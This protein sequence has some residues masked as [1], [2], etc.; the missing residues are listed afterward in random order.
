MEEDQKFDEK[1]Y[2][3]SMRNNKKIQLKFWNKTFN[4][5]RYSLKNSPFVILQRISRSEMQYWIKIQRKIFTMAK[6]FTGDG[7]FILYA[8][9]FWKSF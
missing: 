7:N 2:D 8:C 3:F 6:I 4:F 5:S 9:D 1:S